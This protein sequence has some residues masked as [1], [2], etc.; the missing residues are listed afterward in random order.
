M[1]RL[2]W[3]ERPKRFFCAGT[4]GCA[5]PCAISETLP[6]AQRLQEEAF[7]LRL[8]WVRQIM[9]DFLLVGMHPH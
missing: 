1:S 5:A 9:A 4:P 8:E 2:F 7:A 6:D 3:I